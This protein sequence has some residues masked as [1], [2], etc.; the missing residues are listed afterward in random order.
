MPPNASD[1]STALPARP[2]G[3]RSDARC[4]STSW[5][6]PRWPVRGGLRE[7]KAVVAVLDE[8]R[9]DT[10]GQSGAEGRAATSSTA[11]GGSTRRSSRGG[12]VRSR[13]SGP[14]APLTC[15]RWPSSRPLGY[16]PA[17]SYRR[18]RRL[19]ARHQAL[20]G[21]GRATRGGRG[22]LAE[23]RRAG[24]ASGRPSGCGKTTTSR[25]SPADRADLG[26]DPIGDTDV[27][28]RNVIELRRGIGYVIQQVGCS[29]TRPSPR[30]RHGSPA[31]GWDEN[32][33]APAPRAARAR[34]PRADP[35]RGPLPERTLGR[36]APARGLARPSPRSARAPHGRAVRRRRP[37]VSRAAPERAAAASR[38]SSPRRSCS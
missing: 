11:S 14:H 19:R 32:G 6:R 27:M 34:G 2:R 13:R 33:A 7:G 9:A 16:A 24:P 28:Q 26:P 4:S 12:A 25:W 29:R 23:S 21:R 1:D 35:V 31:A 17:V 10:L 15:G 38:S 5:T 8:G 22:P 20:P 37:V 30:R 36:R 18:A 3:P